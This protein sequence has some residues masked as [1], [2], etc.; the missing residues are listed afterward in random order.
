MVNEV[1]S[2][3]WTELEPHLNA[4]GF[5]LVEVEYGHQDGRQVLRVYLDCDGGITLDQCAEASRM[6][7]PVLDTADFVDSKYVLEVSSPGI[8]RPVRK[9]ADF[10][11]FAGETIR[12]TTHALVNGRRRFQG[13]IGGLDDGMVRLTIEDGEVAI[14]LDNIKT[15][16]LVR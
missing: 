16:K 9:P 10:E 4:C 14:H 2:R 1:I 8:E 5:E 6:I 3:A 7:S 13:V 15:A 12:I 11:R